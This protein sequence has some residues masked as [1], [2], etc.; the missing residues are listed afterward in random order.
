MGHSVPMHVC[1]RRCSGLLSKASLAIEPCIYR[2]SDSEGTESTAEGVDSNLAE[3][4][5]D[6]LEDDM[7]STP[8]PRLPFCWD[9]P[10]PCQD[11]GNEAMPSVAAAVKGLQTLCSW[12]FPP[13][14]RQ[15]QVRFGSSELRKLPS[16][17]TMP[18]SSALIDSSQCFARVGVPERH[19]VHTQAQI[20]LPR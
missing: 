2:R 1:N 7:G 12:I 10:V 9:P 17:T 15:E 8:T 18:L 3:Y 13:P 16:L 20:V 5:S 6:A 14:V 4:E 11:L 19:P